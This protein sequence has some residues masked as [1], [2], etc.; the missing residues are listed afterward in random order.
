MPNPWDKPQASPQGNPWDRPSAPYAPDLPA[1]VG[2]DAFKSGVYSKMLDVPPGYIYQNLD[3]VDGQMKKEGA[4]NSIAHDI[5]VGSE[6][7]IFGLMDRAY[8]KKGMPETL[9]NPGLLDKFVSGL[10]TMIE[11]LP[12]YVGGGFAGGAAG[13]EVPVVGNLAGAAMGAFAVPDAIRA[14]L[15]DSIE[16]GDV[17]GFGDLMGRIG[18]VAW[19]AGKGAITGLVTHGAGKVAA[20][21]MKAA[22]ELVQTG[23]KQLQQAAA[24]TVTGD[25][26]DG[27]MPH[28]DEFVTNAALIVPLGMAT[29]GA[30]ILN[31]DARKA[32]MDRY[33][34]SGNTPDE[35]ALKLQAQPHDAEDLKPGLRA[36]IKIG[37]DHLAANEGESHADFA[38]RSLG[39]RPVTIDEIQ[40]NPDL[41]LKVLQSTEIH[42]QDVI[43]AAWIQWDDA[44]AS[45]QGPPNPEAAAEIEKQR[46]Q[47]SR[48]NLK[49]GRG[50]ETPNGKF[51]TREQ[52]KR[53]VEKNE[54]EVYKKWSDIAEQVG[55]TELHTEDYVEARKRVETRNAIDGDPNLNAVTPT[56][57]TWLK[58]L[59]EQIA[60][61][62]IKADKLGDGYGAKLIRGFLDS[63]D[64][65]LERG[66]FTG[67]R[68]VLRADTGQVAASLGK[69]V[70]DPT[71]QVALSF[72]RDYK[73]DP[74]LLNAEIAKAETDENLKKYVPAMKQA[75][76]P[77]P[78]MLE[79]DKVLNAYFTKYLELG[80]Q[81]GVL[82]SNIDPNKYSPRLFSKTLAPEDERATFF[83]QAKF[84]ERDANAIQRTQLHQLDALKSGNFEAKTFNAVDELSIYG[85]RISTAIATKL[86]KTEL[87]NS[88]M[89]KYG[90]RSDVPKNWVELPGSGNEYGSGFYVPPKIA[91]TMRP[92]L[93]PNVFSGEGW[94]KN[95]RLVQKFTKAAE[96]SFSFFHMKAETL[97]SANN[98]S[99]SSAD[100]VRQWA[101]S[102]A[103]SEFKAQELEGTL[104]GLMTTMT[105]KPYEA[106]QKN[107]D[108]PISRGMVRSAAAWTGKEIQNAA[109]KISY[110]TFDVIQRKYK[111]NDFSMK[112]A[113]WI[114]D[115]P[116][117]TDGEYG[118]AMRGIAKEVNAV[119]G[120]LNWEVMG[121]SNNW[122]EIIRAFV[123]APDWTF[124]NVAGMKY[125]LTDSGTAGQ[126]SREF[127]IKS[128]ITGAALTQATSLMVSGQQ[129]KHWN[130][131]Y[132]G[133]DKNGKELYSN[134][135]FAGLPKDATTWITRMQKD[136]GLR[137]TEEFASYKLGPLVGTGYRVLTNKD[138]TGQPI[139]KPKDTS[140]E[141]TGK[142][143]KFAAQE[144][145][146]VPFGVGT[147]AKQY[148]LKDAIH[149]H[150]VSDED[151]TY[152]DFLGSLAGANIKHEGAKPRRSGGGSFRIPGVGRSGYPPGWKE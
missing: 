35:S 138:W 76:N 91:K 121:V 87:K 82:D 3:E 111:V 7:S 24:M 5:Q 30:K 47:A 54:P 142:Q 95:L 152:K 150:L 36:A 74:E 143:L 22:P 109:A 44:M 133:K 130:E 71:E 117:A 1:G 125:A 29:H 116:E 27:R 92:I 101:H 86:F 137:G 57:L 23:V 112:Q 49:S 4:S 62:K 61:N 90:T 129:S 63:S 103:S 34:E 106:Y 115:H 48:G 20:P 80:R 93:D 81:F 149:G 135:Y 126:A 88:E 52:A 59:R 120:G 144:T 46:L 132:L 39:Q 118:K 94:F 96:L 84:T 134:M 100:F 18:D 14:G 33:A 98:M 102:N 145:L 83:P 73:G 105:G 89:G 146:P 17:K 41:A 75:L 8:E 131:V 37:N 141:K 12:F 32:L 60:L 15:M 55:Q 45:I 40:A 148:S 28:A 53:W 51:L 110:L 38:E 64:R 85:D 97:M 67:A 140:L 147:I 56:Y 6:S 10:S 43:D 107:D 16:K 21:F 151:I 58:G 79:A 119:Y 69:L 13:S 108:L 104:Y 25:L 124:S 114:T 26:L 70:S 19:A 123:L 66:L 78:K 11:D 139:D 50:F 127:L 65:Q 136:G 77:T 99:W 72:M 9:Q 31:S 42:E 113:A 2:E 68:N 128:F 122:Q